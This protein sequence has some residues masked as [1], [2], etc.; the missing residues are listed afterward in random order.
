MPA[1]LFGVFSMNADS[2]PAIVPSDK[3]ASE[4]ALAA[5]LNSNS[6]TSNA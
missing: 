2:G 5:M 4:R 3:L 6:E 1:P